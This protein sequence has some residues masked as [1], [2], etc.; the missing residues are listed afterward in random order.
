MD[1]C[2]IKNLQNITTFPL[3]YNAVVPK[4]ML[5]FEKDG[6]CKGDVRVGAFNPKHSMDDD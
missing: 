4:T 6:C 1:V 2:T 3:W 5:V